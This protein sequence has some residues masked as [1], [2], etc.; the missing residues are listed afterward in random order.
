MA[1]QKDI[2]VPDSK[3]SLSKSDN[4]KEWIEKRFS[5]E[6]GKGIC[7][8]RGKSSLLGKYYQKFIGNKI[9]LKIYNPDGSEAEKSGNG[10][11][12]FSRYLYESN[13]ISDKFSAPAC[14]CL[15]A[16]NEGL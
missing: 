3:L 8:A 2:L 4:I 5:S 15:P 6:G 16:I 11:R 7:F 14:I 13:Y 9:N 12:I 10:V 1:K